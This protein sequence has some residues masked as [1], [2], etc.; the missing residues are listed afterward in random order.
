MIATGLL[1]A[2]LGYWLTEIVFRVE[3]PHGTLIVRSEDPDVQISVKNDGREI[4][5]FFPKQGREI[6]LKI[7]EYTLEL[8]GGK[9]A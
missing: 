1:I 7:G 6:P 4:A 9:R 2:A 8:V 5:L 3:T